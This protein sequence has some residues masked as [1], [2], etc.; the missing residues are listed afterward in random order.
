MDS[1]TLGKGRLEIWGS[2]I[3]TR[4]TGSLAVHDDAKGP[5]NGDFVVSY[6]CEVFMGFCDPWPAAPGGVGDP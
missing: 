4:I 2:L 1:H 6:A 3:G 5:V